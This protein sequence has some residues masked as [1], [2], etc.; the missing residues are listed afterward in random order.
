MEEKAENVD[1]IQLVNLLFLNGNI[2]I[3]K[4]VLNKD[5]DETKLKI[6]N[7]MCKINENDDEF[8]FN[9]IKELQHDDSLQSLIY[10]FFM[11]LVSYPFKDL[12]LTRDAISN[13]YFK[14]KK[15]KQFINYLKKFEKRKIIPFFF[16]VEF[17]AYINIQKDISKD[18]EI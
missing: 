7:L 4:I 15:E 16:M 3:K 6:I 12:I 13:L 5:E 8:K 9:K 1:L 18:V 14:I 2:R 17:I 10:I 11:N